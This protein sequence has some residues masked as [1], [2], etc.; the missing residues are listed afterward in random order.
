ME[1]FYFGKRQTDEW[2]TNSGCPKPE[3]LGVLGQSTSQTPFL[4]GIW[5]GTWPLRLPEYQ[6][7]INY[8]VRINQAVL[9]RVSRSLSEALTYPAQTNYDNYTNQSDRT[10]MLE[11]SLLIVR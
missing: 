3:Y 9:S 1:S 4:H 11:N 10:M 5:T 7:T 6:V 8:G 2:R